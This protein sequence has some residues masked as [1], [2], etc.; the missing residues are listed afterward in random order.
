M[1]NR[2][3]TDNHNLKKNKEDPGKNGFEVSQNNI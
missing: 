1:F 2:M 3:E